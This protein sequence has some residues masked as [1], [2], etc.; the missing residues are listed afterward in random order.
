LEAIGAAEF[1]LSRAFGMRHHAQHI[2]SRAADS[3]DILKRPVGIRFRCDFALR[4]RVAENNAVVAFQFSEC[5]LIA[6][7]IAFHVADGDGQHFA[8]AAGV[9]KRSLIVFDSH[10]HRLADIFQ[11]DVAHQRSGKQS[12]LAQNLETVADTEDQPAAG[13]KLAHRF[14]DWRKLRNRPGA[15]IVAVSEATR[16]NDHIAV[17]QIVRIVP[18]E[19]CRLIG[20]VLGGP[21]SIVVAV[22]SGENYDAKFHGSPRIDHG[23]K[24]PFSGQERSLNC[25]VARSVELFQLSPG[26]PKQ[27]TPILPTSSPAL[28]GYSASYL[29]PSSSCPSRH[30]TRWLPAPRSCCRTWDISHLPRVLSR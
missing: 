8:L 22:R 28:I 3:G 17:L 20:H 14:H 29:W 26:T 21:E 23:D 7:I 5:R 6:K 16:H 24:V 9:G 25:R 2:A 18:E 1:G 30:R 15:E 10:L 27:G 19:R 4:I 11:S 13:G 12:R